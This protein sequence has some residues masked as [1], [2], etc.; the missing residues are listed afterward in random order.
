MRGFHLR[1]ISQEV[2]MDLIGNMFSKITLSKL[3]Q[4]PRANAFTNGESPNRR[5]YAYKLHFP[6]VAP[7][8][9]MD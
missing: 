7:F 1:A 3:V 4:F 8:T 6:P 9:N 2:L 5:I